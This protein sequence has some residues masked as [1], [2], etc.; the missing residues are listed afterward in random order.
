VTFGAGANYASTVE[1]QTDAALKPH[2]VVRRISMSV[3]SILA[4]P[5]IVAA[6]E[7]IATFPMRGA[8]AQ[9]MRLPIKVFETPFR[10]YEFRISMVWHARTHRSD[11][12]RWLRDAI[13]AVAAQALR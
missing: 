12:H 11:A 4:L 8:Q 10:S 6:S 3:P 9:A 1:A 13:R 5:A 2:D 7:L